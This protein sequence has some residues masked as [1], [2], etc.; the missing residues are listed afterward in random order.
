MKKS[1]LALKWR[2]K[3]QLKFLSGLFVMALVL[4]TVLSVVIARNYRRSMEAYYA[5]VVFNEAK[6]AAETIDG[7]KIAEYASTLTKDDYYEQVRQTLQKVKRIVGLKYFYVVIPYEDQMFYVWD[8]GDKGEAGVCDLGDRDDYYGG[9]QEIMRGVFLNREKEEH[10]LITNNDEYGYLASAYVTIRDSRGNP[11]ALSSVDISM[12]MINARIN[13]LIATIV[14]IIASVLSLFIIGYFFVIRLTVLKPIDTLGKAAKTIVREQMDDLATFSV[15]IKTGD[16]LESLADAFTR[17]ARELHVYIL[18]LSMVTAEKERIGAE[19]S[20]AANIQANMLPRVFPPFPNRREI[21]IYASMRPA[22]EVGGDFYDFF[23]VND[24]V[25]A[26]VIADVSGKGVPAALFMVVARTLIKSYAQ[27]GKLL[28]E[29]F[30]NVNN[31]LCENNETS[32]FVTTFMGFLDLNT[33][34]LAYVNAGHNPPLLSQSGEFEY[35]KLKSGLALAAMEDVRYR[36]GFVTLDKSDVLFLYTD[37][38][39]EA[40]DRQGELFGETRLKKKLR[41][42]T[43]SSVK[44]LVSAVNAEIDAFTDGAEQSD[45]ITLLAIEWRADDEK[46]T[47]QGKRVSQ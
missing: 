36:E 4:I 22:K 24:S 9:G 7:N 13:K 3:L 26:I 6:I 38:V 15:N 8:A 18:N 35:M 1:G 16:E 25:L 44:D 46:P 14:L 20:V 39:T 5:N 12:D 43:G 10:I 29:V 45:D 33:G 32:M 19:L 21:D 42:L 41:A 28:S 23:F 2:G 11:V 34:D 47:T 17:M 27:S 40:T 37:G 30:A 31:A